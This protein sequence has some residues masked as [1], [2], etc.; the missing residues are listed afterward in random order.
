MIEAVG[1]DSPHYQRVIELGNA[2]SKTLGFL[3][4]EAINQAATEGR[5]LVFVDDGEV[6]GYA[7]YG[8]R[9]KTGDISLT[10]LCVDQ[11]QRGTGI[12]RE[13]VEDI[14]KRNPHRAG[15]RLSCR[16]DYPANFMWPKLGFQRLGEKPGRSRAGHPLVTWWLPIAAQ[17]LFGEP[18]RED[19][20]LLVAIDT[21]ILLDIL[22]PRDFPASLAL[23]ADWVTE[24]AELAVTGQSHSE[25]SKQRHRSEEFKSALSEFR[26]LEPLHAAWQTELDSLKNESSVARL[27]DND[28]RVVAQA[29]A[30]DAAY[31]VTRDEDLLKQAKHI[32]QLTGLNLVGPDDLLLRLQA[33]GGEHSHQARTI[34]ASDMSF[35]TV[36]QMPSSAEL[37]VYCHQHVAERPTELRQRLGISTAHGGR[38]EQ[39]VADSGEHLALGALYS[40]QAR[41]TVTALRSTSGQ[42]SYAAARQMIHHLRTIVANDE[43]AAIVIEDQTN[44]SVERALRDEGFR[45]EGST[46]KAVVETSVFRRGDALPQELSQVGWDRLNAS[47]VRE[48]ERYAWPSKVFSGGVTSYVVPIKPEYARVLLGYEEPQTRLFEFHLRAAVSRDN[49]YYM[50]PRPSIETP[51]RIIW[52]VS[53][54]GKL[55]GVRA[56]SWLDAVDTGDPNSLYRKYRDRGVLEKAQVLESARPSGESDHLTATA[57]LFSQSEIFPKPVSIDKARELCP[58]MNQVGYL[59]TTRRIDEVIVQAF[60]EEGLKRND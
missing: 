59:I 1:T 50:A 40:E 9:V 17:S 11:E 37:S 39:L 54:G 27:K 15:I 36:S 7:L 19:A 2:N 57:L 58:D 43:P 28:L 18:E 8:K 30:S 22:E 52:W 49:T 33:L 41:V 34:A 51:A 25:L 32:E 29:A 3:P 14:V 5:V 23:I 16:K 42:H 48:F 26:T 13:L 55:G 31:L 12:A 35:M 47:L 10:H 6:K 56:M 44:Q 21:N 45:S 4:Y 38:V 20:R 53:G 60:Y 24:D 46:W